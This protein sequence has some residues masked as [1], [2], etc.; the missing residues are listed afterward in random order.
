[1]RARPCL[2]R[3][4]RRHSPPP[5]R[6]KRFFPKWSKHP[7]CS[8]GGTT[9]QVARPRAAIR[10]IAPLSLCALLS[11]LRSPAAT[12]EQIEFF[13]NRIRP[14]LAQECYECHSES[15]K[16]KGGLLL[17][18]RPGWQ[19]GGDTGPAIVPGDAAA[20]LLIQSIRHA[21]ADLQMPKNGAKLDDNI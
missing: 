15:G 1:R 13:E 16:R 14:V 8:E 3:S 20:S 12:P 10:M 11:A 19:A 5:A 6:M 9:F 18:S 17:D 4:R 21:H 7:A 2:R